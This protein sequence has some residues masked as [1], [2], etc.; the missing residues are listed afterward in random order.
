M[1]NIDSIGARR[2]NQSEWSLECW[3]RLHD[4]YLS[5]RCHI[6]YG[7]RVLDIPDGK[8]KW[9]GIDEQSDLLDEQGRKKE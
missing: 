2:L 1:M 9:S 7:K 6:F 5:Y 8:P 4:A 3:L